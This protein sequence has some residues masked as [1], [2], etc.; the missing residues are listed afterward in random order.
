MTNPSTD[1]IVSA[2]YIFVGE[3]LHALQCEAGNRFSWVTGHLSHLMNTLDHVA[4]E[5]I[6]LVAMCLSSV[7]QVALRKRY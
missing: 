7:V 4:V 2:R 5:R 6:W 1:P 3:M